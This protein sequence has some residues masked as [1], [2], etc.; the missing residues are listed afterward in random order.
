[1]FPGRSGINRSPM[2]KESLAFS[3]CQN[4]RTDGRREMD[5]RRQIC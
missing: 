3:F 5:K 1:M 4:I 2:T